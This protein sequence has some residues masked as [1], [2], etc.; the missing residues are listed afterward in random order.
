MSSDPVCP[1]ATPTT[2]YNGCTSSCCGAGQ[3][4]QSPSGG[5]SG[6]H[7]RAQQQL[8]HVTLSARNPARPL[9]TRVRP[10]RERPAASA[11]ACW[12]DF[13]TSGTMW[14]RCNRT[15]SRDRLT[16]SGHG[17]I[18]GGSSGR[19]HGMAYGWQAETW[20]RLAPARDWRRRHAGANRLRH[21]PPRRGPLLLT[22]TDEMAIS[23]SLPF[24]VGLAAADRHA[25][26]SD[27]SVK[28][29]T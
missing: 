17:R 9:P 24:L 15:R 19:R 7:S 14:S 28:P 3:Q 1:L 21:F 26:S 22:L 12:P 8:A 6:Q 18:A 20:G 11:I 10:C 16:C 13:R 29:A 4:H 27:V 25:Q 5:R 2:A 23:A